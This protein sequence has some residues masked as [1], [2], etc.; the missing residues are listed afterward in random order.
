MVA[1]PGSAD[2]RP[3]GAVGS[4]NT[5]TYSYVCPGGADKM[6]CTIMVP[7]TYRTQLF[8]PGWQ[9]K[10]TRG[11]HQVWSGKL[12]EPV[13]TT[14]G[15]NL[16]AVGTGNRGQD[17]LAIYTST[18]PA[19]EPDQSINN[20]I[21][22]GLPWINPGVGTPSGAWF[23]Q[24]VDSGAQTVTDLLNLVCTRGGLTWY[25]NSQPGGQPG[26]DLSV[27]PL[28]TVV[29]RLL[30]CIDPVPRTLGGDI[31]TIYLRYQATAD[32]SSNGGTA[33]TFA[34]TSVQNAASV[35][36]HQE[37]ETYIDISDAG[38]MTAASA[39]AVGSKVLAIYQRASFAG[40]FTAHYG[41]LT[42]TG[43]A[44]VDPGTDQAGTMVKLILTD[45]GFGGE[46][47]PQFPVTFIVGAYEWDDLAQ[48]ATITPYQTV[49]ESLTGLLTLANN[50]LTP[51][52]VAST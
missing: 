14:S 10:I 41:Q 4:V 19:S 32:N 13:P 42:N 40:P 39:Q 7:A 18:W 6:S 38:V 51:V 3:L 12:D 43:G 36:A 33:A 46:V 28:P 2:W 44:P 9:V 20:A 23:G 11:G 17:Y 47:T 5:L 50:D 27:F 30:T 26:D 15:W 37:I 21:S 31:N 24:G 16:T 35:T 49:D 22:R 48:T 52:T 1:P 25:V 45:F 34:I 8:N 29:N